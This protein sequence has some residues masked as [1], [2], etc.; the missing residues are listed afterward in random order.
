MESWFCAKQ[1]NE[2]DETGAQLDD[3]K[4]TELLPSE[5]QPWIPLMCFCA[6]MSLIA[7]LNSV[8]LLEQF[9]IYIDSQ[10]G[11]QLGKADDLGCFLRKG[12]LFFSKPNLLYCLQHILLNTLGTK[13]HS[14]FAVNTR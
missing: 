2:S 13:C 6:F 4:V 11:L 7:A 14:N 10:E 5:R 3:D 12:A 1:E 9:R 8:T